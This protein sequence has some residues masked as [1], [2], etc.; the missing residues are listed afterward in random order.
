MSSP[1]PDAAIADAAAPKRSTGW[2]A[3]WWTLGV[4]GTVVL[5][6]V[7]GLYFFL[8]TSLP[9]LSGEMLTASI[10]QPVRIT[11]DAAGVPTLTART[12]N[13]LAFATGL[14]HAQD[15]F[16]Q[17]DLLRRVSAGELAQLLGPSVLEI[18][19]GSRLHDFRRVVREVLQQ[20]SETERQL[21][22]AY[23]AGVNFGLSRQ[24]ASWEYSVLGSQ[25]RP[26][27]AEDCVLAGLSLFLSLGD[28]TGQR[29]RSRGLL[30]ANLP[31]A[32]FAFITPV[33]TEW[34]APLRGG[35]WRSAPI[36]G[37]D[38]F[39]LRGSARAARAAGC[40]DEEDLSSAAGS[41]AWA[42]AGTHTDNGHALLA[43][44]MHLDLRL[45]H[46]WYRARL[47]IEADEPAVPPGSE[48]P[49]S[50]AGVPA[51]DGPAA[52]KSVVD[53][54]R[55]LIGVTLP[56]LPAMLAGSNGSVAWGY[57]NSWGD[58]TDVV[59]V[60]T[61]GAPPDHY[62][63]GDQAEPFQ[64]RRET[65]E[66][67]GAAAVT[68]EVRATRWGPIIGSE[69]GK[70]LA[71]AWTAHDPRATNLRL[72]EFETAQTLEQLLDAANR[73]GAP[74]QNFVAAQSDGRIGWTF[75]G[76]VP[77]RAN[78]YEPTVP[79]SWRVPGTGWV[80]WRQPQ[81][82]PRIIEPPSGR[83]WSANARALEV[84]AWLEFAGEGAYDHGARAGQIRDGLFMLTR[85]SAQDM[86]SIQLDD[87][88]LF[89][90]RWRDLLLDLLN[91]KTVAASK[92][93]AQAQNLIKAWSGHAAVDD[94]GYRIVRQFRAQVNRDVFDDFAA[95]A[96]RAQP[97][98]QLAPTRQ[99]EGPLWQLVTQR[100]LHL[101][102]PQ[103][104]TW[105][106]AL[107]ASLDMALAE[108]VKQCGRLEQCS[109]GQH[110]TLQMQHPI[111]AQLPV[112]GRLLNMPSTPLPGDNG[113]PRVQGP[114]FGAS[115]RVVVSP[116]HEAEGYFQMPGGP[117]NHPLSP[118]YA[119][120]H[121]EWARGEPSPLLPGPAKFTLT[122]QPRPQGP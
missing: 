104:A 40:C 100:P 18:D 105:E 112:V 20:S 82:Y 21:L 47:Q 69:A 1:T 23:T 46:V 67:R 17:M 22:N 76:Q 80:G 70:P 12:R 116:G 19:R 27:V 85:A 2:R 11:R 102:D 56:G 34:D 44:D 37:P 66:V 122:L 16:F 115:Q 103:F 41:N 74:V 84:P 120:G 55:D 95:A 14:V 31:P 35:V 68:L 78:N 13:D 89:L 77:V 108:L 97:D 15:R 81:E 86:V 39:D 83:I 62:W 6:L 32:V 42:V 30:R 60:E 38:V 106:D 65:L 25:P 58:W 8:R 119:K 118:F 26:W 4:L 114:Q 52:E 94:V 75:M 9:Q 53:G 54:P 28:S 113:M 109:W 88:A 99:F 29:E 101:L 57:T 45:P 64:V 5:A 51:A 33:G 72:F 71:L 61:E 121:Q 59:I 7:L 90:I 49:A 110:N 36:P 63:V 93:R 50:A 48:V 87:R 24:R 3:V 98:A 111:A 79:N 73:V 96:R 107:L 117:V 43:N 91:D 92:E 10:A